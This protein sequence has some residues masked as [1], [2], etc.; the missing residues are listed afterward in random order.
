M[1]WKISGI[2]TVE[3]VPTS[4]VLVVAY[5]ETDWSLKGWAYSG[6]D[7]KYEISGLDSADYYFVVAMYAAGGVLYNAPCLWNVSPY[8]VP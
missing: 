4:G 2:C 7:G 3:D 5:S 6:S 8:E 1:V